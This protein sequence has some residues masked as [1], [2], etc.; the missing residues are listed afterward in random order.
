MK[1]TRPGPNYLIVV[2]ALASATLLLLADRYLGDH[3]HGLA[4]Q[5][6][7]AGYTDHCVEDGGEAD[8]AFGPSLD[9]SGHSEPC[10]EAPWAPGTSLL[11]A[12]PAG[13]PGPAGPAGPPGP[14]GRAGPAGPAGPTPSVATVRAAAAVQPG[15]QGPPGPTGP[16]GP[17]GIS[18]YEVVTAK[19]V[20]DPN[21]RGQR[22]VPC[23]EGKVALSGGVAA[24]PGRPA[25]IVVVQS[26]PLLGD[27]P[28]RGWRATV[29]HVADAADS[30]P[31]T[32]IVSAICAFAR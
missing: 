20:L 30:G 18:G 24:A 16:A 27:P 1:R 15:P 32:V 9:E 8:G 25:K 21:T 2:V 14:E 4:D 22:S 12:G 11:T 17:E 23:P 19:L 13:P 29:E 26:T 31:V 6:Q 7:L 28:G 3:S 5:S 10:P